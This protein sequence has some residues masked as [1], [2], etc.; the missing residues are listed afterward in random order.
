MNSLKISFVI[1]AF[2]VASTIN[3]CFESI[4]TLPLDESEFEVIIIDDC[5]TDNTVDLIQQYIENHANIVLLCQPENHRQGAARNR[6]ISVA[7]GVFV[8]FVD[9]DDETSKGVVDAINMAD[10]NDLDMV[11]MRFSKIGCDGKTEKEV[12]L[13]YDS[14]KVF[15]GIEMQTEFPFWSTASWSYIYRKA[16]IDH[17]NYPFVEDVLYEDSDFV[18]IHLHKAKR[19]SYSDECGYIIHNNVNSTTQTISYKHIC[20]YALLGIRMLRFFDGL[21][22]KTSPYSEKILEGG[23]Y[24]IMT[25]LR[26][27]LELKSRSEVRDFYDRFD[28]HYDRKLLMG[29]R[30]P[31]YCWNWWTRFCLKHRRIIIVIMGCTIPIVKMIK[32]IK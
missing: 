23:S 22:D 31:A 30:K 8:V 5:S 25:A 26:K 29:Y 12:S 11:A 9:S 17:V 32:K 19:M 6:G 15:S 7:K 16:F 18:N 10:E 24:N 13:P 20:D 3:R 28:S 2:N 21:D 14:K 27:L 1:P 4:Y